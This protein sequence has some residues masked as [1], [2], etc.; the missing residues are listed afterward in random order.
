M[1]E[2]VRSHCFQKMLTLL[3]VIKVKRDNIK[4]VFQVSEKY[5]GG[6]LSSNENIIV[7]NDD[8]GIF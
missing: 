3:P 6:K 5:V 8:P 1:S 4:G 7:S 2:I